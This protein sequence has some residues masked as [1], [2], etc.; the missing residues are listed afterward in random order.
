MLLLVSF[1][2][3]WR[4]VQAWHAQP[5]SSASCA[6]WSALK[7]PSA[8]WGRVLSCTFA[9]RVPFANFLKHCVESRFRWLAS[10]RG[11]RAPRFPAVTAAAARRK[12]ARPGLHQSGGRPAPGR[13]PNPGRDFSPG[14]DPAGATA[15][16]RTLCT[17]AGR[18]RACRPSGS[19]SPWALLHRRRRS[20]PSPPTMVSPLRTTGC[21]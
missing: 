5:D 11:E 3:A 17:S 18:T 7:M 2:C 8:D 9:C 20:L 12:E 14:R 16:R 19:P 15:G 10:C 21:L 6:D 13:D 1:V 4:H